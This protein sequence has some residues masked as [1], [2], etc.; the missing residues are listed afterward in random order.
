MSIR[1]ISWS[2]LIVS[3]SLLGMACGPTA[4]AQQQEAAVA[5]EGE[6]C[7]GFAGIQCAK[8][9]TCVDDPNDSCDPAQGGRD[10]AG[11]CVAENEQK[12]SCEHGP[13]YTYVSRDPAQ[14]A[15]ILFKCPGGSEAFFNDCGCG[16]KTLTCDFNDPN[17]TYVSR[18]PNQCAV[19]RYTCQ[20]GQQAFS[21]S[22]GCGCET[23]P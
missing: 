15:A 4:E 21:D 23:L 14:C 22:C 18:D 1:L 12:L 6:F 9:L 19:I 8:G 3:A 13:E 20:P 2:V 5:S 16:C 11:I 17:R 7:G 10:C